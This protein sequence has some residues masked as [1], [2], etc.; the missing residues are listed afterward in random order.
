M[1]HRRSFLKIKKIK[2]QRSKIKRSEDWI[3]NPANCTVSIIGFTIESTFFWDQQ[4]DL[5]M[6]KIE[7]LPLILTVNIF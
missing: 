3:P 1:D 2:D 6:K 5:I 4:I 7:S